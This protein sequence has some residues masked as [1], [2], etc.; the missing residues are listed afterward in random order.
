MK[1]YKNLF[2]GESIEQGFEEVIADISV[3]KKT[4]KRYLITL[5]ANK[6]NMLDIITA[7]M[8]IMI[9][10]REVYVIG[11]AG[12]KNEALNMTADLVLS[13]YKETG[14]FNFEDFFNDYI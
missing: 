13:V 5:P 10:W 7:K 14:D 3:N 6:N 9:T 1:W 11:V 4:K 12:S 8:G 2:I